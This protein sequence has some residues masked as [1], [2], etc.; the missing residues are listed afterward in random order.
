MTTASYTPTSDSITSAKTKLRIFGGEKT[1]WDSSL[2]S[3][4]MLIIATLVLAM[5]GIVMV[6]SSS[7]VN[8]ITLNRSPYFQ[9]RSQLLHGGIG[10]VLLVA[11]T[12]IKPNWL[13]KFVWPIFIGAIILQAL[14]FAPAPIGVEVNG[15]R[16]WVDL[17]LLPIFQPAELSKLALVLWLGKVLAKKQKL[18]GDWRE[19]IPPA[20]GA[21][22]LV[23]L[24][25]GGRDLGTAMIV[26]MLVIG[27][28]LI[29]GTPSKTL[30]IAV[31]VVAAIFVPL[32]IGS[33]NRS[34]RVLSL[35]RSCGLDE[36]YQVA[37][38]RYAL[39]TGGLFGV[40]VG[41]SRAK[42]NY[43]PAAQDDFIFAIIGEE[44]GLIGALVVLL[45]FVCL[46]LAMVRIIK[47]HPDPFARITTAAIACWILGQAI[48]NIGV[49]LEV[50]PVVGVP[51][52]LLSSGG[53]ALVVTLG[54]LGV[55][56]HFARFEP[57]AW[58]ELQAKPSWSKRGLTVFSS[59]PLRA[60]TPA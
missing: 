59:R 31:G 15:N 40:G 3:Y 8:S 57:S 45:L 7:T 30:W 58:A 46:G 53:S 36:C 23:G 24:I 19:S 39:A 17:P 5:L 13:P 20:L 22:L 44:L 43:L 16:G 35:F 42:W 54:A 21:G 37:N 18:L 33:E 50:I 48:V 14:T 11:M 26:A 41:G 51:L 34:N 9:F 52:P 12:R 60:V 1:L 27:A 49:V 38:G 6:L 25:L 56:M 28:F 47:N 2:T 55:V 10:L 32:V 29:A 4:Y